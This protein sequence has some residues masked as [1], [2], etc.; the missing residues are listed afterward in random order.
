MLVAVHHLL[1]GKKKLDAADANLIGATLSMMHLQVPCIA[2]QV[3][4][5][6]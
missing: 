1:V 5:L 6:K 4:L 2:S 3:C